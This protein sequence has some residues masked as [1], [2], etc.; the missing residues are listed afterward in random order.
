MGSNWTTYDAR[1]DIEFY[2]DG[3]RDALTDAESDGLISEEDAEKS[4]KLLRKIE[5][6]A[7]LE[8]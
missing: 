3:L 2:A 4:L 5:K 1:Y 8:W 7:G 6:I